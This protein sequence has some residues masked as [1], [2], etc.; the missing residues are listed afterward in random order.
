[1]NNPDFVDYN[2]ENSMGK[3]TQADLFAKGLFED[4]HTEAYARKDDPGTSHE[5]ARKVSLSNRERMVFSAMCAMAPRVTTL[6]ITRYLQD[7]MAESGDNLGWS[8]SPRMAP[9]ERK[10]LIE[11]DG[12]MTVINSSGNPAPLGAWRLAQG[13][14]QCVISPTSS[15]KLR[16]RKPQK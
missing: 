4:N 16:Q 2:K 3:D 11:R 1:M 13:A 8:V 9:L 10:G 5:A 7:Q 12:R 15:R 6:C 14:R